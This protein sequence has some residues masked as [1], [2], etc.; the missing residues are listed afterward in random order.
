MAR[1]Q[2]ARYHAEVHA[3]ELRGGIRR[4]ALA[5][6][7]DLGV[8]R[9]SDGIEQ[10][11]RQFMGRVEAA[12]TDA[13]YAIAELQAHQPPEKQAHPEIETEIQQFAAG[14][15]HPRIV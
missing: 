6:L 11:L 5:L 7:D 13:D 15:R 12:R 4:A 2:V 1:P 8:C 14:H 9:T 3:R 10:A